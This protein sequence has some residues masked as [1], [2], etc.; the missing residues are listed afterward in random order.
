M[1]SKWTI[2]GG[3]EIITTP[4]GYNIPKTY[5]TKLNVLHAYKNKKTTIYV[6]AFFDNI[7]LFVDLRIF[8]LSIY[9]L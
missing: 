4:K 3:E 8:F 5:F 1:S 6:V 7:K 9:V 2:G